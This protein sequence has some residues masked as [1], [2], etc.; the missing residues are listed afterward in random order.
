M[1]HEEY[2]GIGSRESGQAE[3]LTTHSILLCTTRYVVRITFRDQTLLRCTQG[4]APLLPRS[5][6]CMNGSGKASVKRR[7][8]HLQ[9]AKTLQQ[10]CDWRRH[11]PAHCVPFI[12]R[13]SQRYEHAK[14]ERRR[15]RERN[16]KDCHP[17]QALRSTTECAGSKR[18]RA[19]GPTEKSDSWPGGFR[20]APK[21]QMATFPRR[22]R[23]RGVSPRQARDDNYAQTRQRARRLH[24]AHH[25]N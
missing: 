10:R 5:F 24:R 17:G 2:I 1:I 4:E 6:L 25:G 20:V 7:A 22:A 23:L 18:L 21:T 12:K 19:N 16:H 3:T 8:R 15:L 13:K 11:A 14:N 9:D